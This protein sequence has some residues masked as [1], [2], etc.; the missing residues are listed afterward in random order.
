MGSDKSY[1]SRFVIL[2]IIEIFDFRFIER[3]FDKFIEDK[4]IPEF[5]F[6]PVF[7]IFTII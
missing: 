6:R 2:F 7:V 5:K 4:K 1:V 3:M